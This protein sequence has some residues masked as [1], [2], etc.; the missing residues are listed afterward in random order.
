[1]WQPMRNKRRC[2]RTQFPL[3]VSAC[4]RMGSIGLLL[5][6]ALLLTA[7][8]GKKDNVAAAAPPDVLV[9]EV[10]QQDVPISQEWVATLTGKVNAD[11]HAQVAGYLIKQDYTNGTFVRKSAPLFQIDPRPFHAALD[12]AKAN[13]AQ[14]EGSLKQK[15]A[16]LEEAKANQ[17]RA[18][19]ELGKS[20]IDV[21]RYT[22]LARENAISQQELD[23]AVQANLAAKAQLDAMKA[24]VA[25][26]TASIGTAA[27][28]VGTANAA[29]ETTQLN[30]GFTSIVSPVDGV[31]GIA[32][33]QVG[34]LVG[35]Q[36]ST[37]TTVSTLS[38]ILAQFTPSEE[39]YLNTAAQL[40]GAPG[41]GN[42]ALKKLQFKLLLA[43]GST[44]P[45]K[46]RIYAINREVNAATGTI[47]VQAE[48]P[49]AANVLR[50][51]G[52]G[53]INTVVRVEK[54]ALAVPQVAVA[55]VQGTY[56]IAV[57]DNDNK[58]AI[59]P[60]KVGPKIGTMWVIAQGLKPG[61]RVVAEGVQ[62]VS[63]GLQ[64]NPKPYSPRPLEQLKSSM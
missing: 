21:K 13:L 8:C 25:N 64:V 39:Q 22:P 28:A 19:A 40:G 43:N 50:P 24:S 17:E 23:N 20:E 6:A 9:V 53:R 3:A 41:A 48:F 60:V 29:L 34:D 26:A 2:D 1:M 5:S 30:L 10:Q 36:S 18:D 11:I 31:A 14:A 49:N 55:D 58:V 16:A 46:G 52:F 45:E 54:G 7:G 62:K 15:Q 59:R 38:P 42:E 4:Y 32:N 51:G 33:A 56:L 63:D 61:E 27:A 37:L 57:V 35:P 47:L 12:Q 44:Y